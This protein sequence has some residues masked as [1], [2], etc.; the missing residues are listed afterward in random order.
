MS[1]SSKNGKVNNMRRKVINVG[2]TE[3]GSVLPGWASVWLF[4]GI[5]GYTFTYHAGG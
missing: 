4:H 2:C 5:G 3:V 1:E